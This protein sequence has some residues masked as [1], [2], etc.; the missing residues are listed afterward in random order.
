MLDNCIDDDGNTDTDSVTVTV[1]AL[2]AQSPLA[3]AGSDVTV[4]DGDNDG[5]ETV[6]LDGTGDWTSPTFDDS[7]WV[8]ATEYGG[9]LTEPWAT[10]STTPPA[11]GRSR[12]SPPSGADPWVSSSATGTP[13]RC[14][15]RTISR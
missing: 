6:S 3:A 13:A 11:R 4:T 5:S 7:P 12:E 14:S 1:E 2:S 10:D 9:P 15:S 8:A